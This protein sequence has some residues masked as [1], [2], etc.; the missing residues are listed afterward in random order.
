MSLKRLGRSLLGKALRCVPV[1]TAEGLVDALE[2]RIGIGSGAGVKKS[3]ERVAFEALVRLVDEA[4]TIF[5][6][7]AAHGNYSVEA[8]KR[9]GRRRKAAVHCFEPSQV[10]F[11]KLSAKLGK[12]DNVKLN[13]FA[14][15]DKPGTAHAGNVLRRI[16]KACV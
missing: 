14:L 9:I 7:G 10:T 3:G 1:R 2:R 5:D 8:I 11:D 12:R 6:V 15:A 16:A 13:R 4:V